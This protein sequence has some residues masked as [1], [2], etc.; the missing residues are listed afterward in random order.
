M[1]SWQGQCGFT[2]L[3][4]LVA[5]AI[6]SVA[7]GVMMQA[8]STGL[9]SQASSATVAVA[10]EIG[11]SKLA[12]VG[13]TIPLQ[14]GETTGMAPGG[15]RWRVSIRPRTEEAV[16]TNY[17]TIVRPMEV[18]VVVR[19]GDAGAEREVAVDTVRLGRGR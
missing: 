10:T 19:W 14:A 17:A 15:Y 5:F 12:E 4:V 16:A 3:E 13:A 11:R 1:R 9:R 2:L 6:L 18:S 7:L 8:F